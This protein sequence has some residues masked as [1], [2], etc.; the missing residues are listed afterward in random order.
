M[1]EINKEQRDMRNKI[2][3]LIITILMSIASSVVVAESKQ[4]KWI[5]DLPIMPKLEIEQGIGFAFDSSE[6]RIVTI[7]LSGE[8]TK[9]EIEK[10]YKKAMDPLGWT[11]IENAKWVR[12]DEIL[13]IEETEALSTKLWKITIR[14]N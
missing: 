2:K 7:F 1:P 5:G 8:T 4:A 9:S 13:I 10:Y 6:G 14:P 11:L 12:E 3:I